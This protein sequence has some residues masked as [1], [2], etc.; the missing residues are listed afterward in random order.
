M[1]NSP[2]SKLKQ[3]ASSSFSTG[4]SVSVFQSTLLMCMLQVNYFGVEQLSYFHG[5]Y[6]NNNFFVC[7]IELGCYSVQ[8]KIRWFIFY[9]I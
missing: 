8:R 2:Q 6:A 1:Q 3:S 5:I 7:V 4:R 9:F